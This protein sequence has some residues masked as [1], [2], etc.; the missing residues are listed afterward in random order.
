[1]SRDI[2]S[3]SLYS[4][5]WYGYEAF[6][7]YLGRGSASPMRYLGDN[8]CVLTCPRGLDAPGPGC[9]I[10]AVHRDE[11]VVIDGL[12]IGCVLAKGIYFTKLI[13]G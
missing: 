11:S 13:S 9:W 5:R 8:V 2:L 6:D 10:L 12:K 3:I 1:M 7:G 4:L